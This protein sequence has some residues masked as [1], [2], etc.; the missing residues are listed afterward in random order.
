VVKKDYETKPQFKLGA[1]LGRKR[2]TAENPIPGLAGEMATQTSSTTGPEVRGPTSDGSDHP[3]KQ[4]KRTSGSRDQDAPGAKSPRS[5]TPRSRGAY[6]AGTE[7]DF[8]KHAV[9]YISIAMKDWFDADAGGSEVDES[10]GLIVLKEVVDLGDEAV[11]SAMISRAVLAVRFPDSQGGQ[12]SGTAAPQTDDDVRRQLGSDQSCDSCE[13]P[14]RFVLGIFRMDT[15]AKEA[16]IFR[17]HCFYHY[18]M[19][20]D[21]IDGTQRGFR[22]DVVVFAMKPEATGLRVAQSVI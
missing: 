7:D 16:R 17:V 20:L 2:Q 15:S 8:L 13:C 22:N 3:P 18:S 14:G 21:Q 11:C 19:L 9:N 1:V 6:P 10:G 4:S 5:L 12:A